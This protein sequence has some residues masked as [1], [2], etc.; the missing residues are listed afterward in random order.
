[1][2][3]LMHAFMHLSILA[4]INY[5]MQQCMGA[6]KFACM[7]THVSRSAL[8]MLYIYIYIRSCVRH[9]VDIA[10]TCVR[11]IR[12]TLSPVSRYVSDMF[13]TSCNCVSDMFQ[14]T[15][16]EHVLYTVWTCL[17]LDGTGFELI[18]EK[19]QT[20]SGHDLDTI[21]IRLT[22]AW[23]IGCHVSNTFQACFGHVLAKFRLVWQMLQT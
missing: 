13:C 1:M 2:H 6:C 21:E 5:C 11:H 17:A 23:T 9:V 3:A 14:A 7:Y 4:S 22:H 8:D 19:F 10:Q 20:I 18:L 12:Q 15:C 16:F